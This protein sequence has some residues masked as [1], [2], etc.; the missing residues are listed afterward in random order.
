MTREER[1]KCLN[2][3]I[4]DLTIEVIANEVPTKERHFLQLELSM[5]ELARKLESEN[6][7]QEERK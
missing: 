2:S 6:A 5:L 3:M 4:S 1:I 7:W